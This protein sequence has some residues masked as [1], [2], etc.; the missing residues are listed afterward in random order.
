MIESMNNP[1]G[2]SM[3]PDSQ[4]IELSINQMIPFPGKLPAALARQQADAET[5]RQ[6]YQMKL[7]DLKKDVALMYYG[8]AS[9]DAKLA[10]ELKKQKQLEAMGAVIAAQY[11][12]GKA[13]LSEF[14]RTTNMKAMVKTEILGM[15][16]E[17]ERMIADLTAMLGKPI[18]K[19]TVFAYDVSPLTHIPTEDEM[20]DTAVKHFPELLMKQAMERRMKAEATQMKLEA[21]PD[22]TLKGAVAQMKNGD[23]TYTVGFSIPLPVYFPVKQIPLAEAAGSMSDAAASDRQD[24]ENKITQ[25]MHSRYTAL[26]AANETLILYQ[27][28]IKSGTE[29]AFELALKDYQINRISFSELI[30]SFGAVYDTAMELEKTK[31][32]VME[33][34]VYIDFYTADSLRW[35]EKS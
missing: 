6:A 27:S 2:S 10:I 34:R 28:S 26:T 25:E 19:D 35:E 9:M 16:A 4:G 22:F 7:A 14:I 18:P 21:I 29:Q 15:Q 17:R 11:T 13:T 8:I 20:V 32:L 3:A 23:K 33:Q 31:Q 12:G 5:A 30:D 24:T 1:L